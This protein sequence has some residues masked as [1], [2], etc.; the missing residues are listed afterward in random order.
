MSDVPTTSAR[1]QLL[2]ADRSHRCAHAS[3]RSERE[4]LDRLVRSGF[5]LAPAPRLYAPARHWHELDFR[6]QALRAIRGHAARRPQWTFCFCSAA[7]VHGLEVSRL[8]PVRT[9]H[10]A[11]GK[12]ELRPGVW[13]HK[14]PADEFEVVGGVRVTTLARTVFDCVRALSFPLALAVADSAARAHTGGAEGLLEDVSR[15]SRH[16]AG[17]ARAREVAR[18]ADPL[19]ENGGE[20]YARA[21]MLELG[22][23]LPL[24]Q[25]PV[26]DPID[27]KE[28]RCDFLWPDAVGGRVAGE[29]DGRQKTDDARMLAGATTAEALR[30]ERLRE[31]RV[32][33]SGL[34]VARFSFG[35]VRSGRSLERLLGA[36][37][38]PRDPQGPLV[39]PTAYRLAGPTRYDLIR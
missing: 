6:E 16:K 15:I 18:R 13:R 37:G 3:S 17:A 5:A 7:L 29:L 32:T 38:I 33:V 26:K 23:E 35:N 39:L 27:G 36:F 21:V 9:V 10:V 24:L 31:S 20:S 34:R 25:V 30:R 4:R 22:F 28:Y 1:D 14:L 2:A 19:S 8:I 11:A 12:T